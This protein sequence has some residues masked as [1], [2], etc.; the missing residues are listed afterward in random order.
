MEVSYTMA[1]W[2][3]SNHAGSTDSVAS[4]GRRDVIGKSRTNRSF[5]SRLGPSLQWTAR[6]LWT[7]YIVLTLIEMI[8]LRFVVRWDYLIRSTMH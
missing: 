3:G 2:H 7:I 6:R 1:R 5:S 4:S 8:L